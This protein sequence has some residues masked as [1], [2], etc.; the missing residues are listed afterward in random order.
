M[1][2]NISGKWESG[3]SL[4]DHFLIAMPSLDGSVFAKSVTYIC[5]HGQHGAM[6]LVINQ[7]LNFTLLE[8]LEHLKIN[9]LG[10]FLPDLV[11][12][13]GPVGVEHGFVLHCETDKNWDT[14][15]SI[16]KNIVLTTSS[17]ILRSIAQSEG[18]EQ[19]L[20]ALGYAGWSPGQLEAEV[21][22]NS[23]L[24]V[25]ADTDIIFCTPHDERLSK[26]AAKIGVDMNLISIDPGH[27]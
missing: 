19:Y 6:G 8:L 25:P 13:G 24:T 18:P 9:V 27:A 10:N 7:P 20:L 17:D 21:A 3:C 15:V 5:E 12:A 16:G 2:S 23:W 22:Q 4:S 11:M 14:C 1:T 26:A